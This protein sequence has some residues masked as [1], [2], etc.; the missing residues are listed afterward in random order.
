MLSSKI[1]IGIITY[2]KLPDLHPGDQEFTSFLDPNLFEV[3]PIVW[4]NPVH[5]PEM[6][7]LIFRSCWDY[8]TQI[9]DFQVFLDEIEAL[10]IPTWNPLPIIKRNLHKFYLE[11]LSQ[12]GIPILPTVF[13]KKGE[14]VDIQSLMKD[15]AWE[16]AVIKPAV[17]AGSTH[18]FLIGQSIAENELEKIYNLLI[19]ND[20]L[21]Q[22]F[23][24]EITTL[25]EVSL[26]FL[27]DGFQY[28]ILKR[29]QAGD[30]RVQQEFGGS[31]DLL[32]LDEEIIAQAR[33]VL[34]TFT[35]DFLFARVDGV[36]L[37]DTFYLMELEMIEPYLF[38]FCH[39]QASEHLANS[40]LK[41][42]NN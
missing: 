24:S 42:L 11:D 23:I 18:T 31:A 4:T 22:K 28:S 38:N 10:K 26:I 25:G 33:K 7:L 9:A 29:P 19:N 12:A 3:Y 40:L 34:D 21:L 27:A 32:M 2:H 37:N 35:N 16:K 41:K 13:L 6:D 5:L 1:K 17:S 30:F 8:H 39:P 15:R 20:L 36:I 14:P